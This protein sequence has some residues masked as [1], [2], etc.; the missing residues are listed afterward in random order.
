MG[1]ARGK[2][3]E[4]RKKTKVKGESLQGKRSFNTKKSRALVFPPGL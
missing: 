4:K 3:K 2:K 1:K